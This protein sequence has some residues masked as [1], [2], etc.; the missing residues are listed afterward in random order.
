MINDQMTDVYFYS[1]LCVIVINSLNFS[2][3]ITLE[4]LLFV[5]HSEEKVAE[6]CF[7]H[8]KN[9]LLNEYCVL[10]SPARVIPA[11][12]IYPTS[13][14]GLQAH[15]PELNEGFTAGSSGGGK[16]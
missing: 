3:Y 12:G 15:A 10:F 16:H 6:L 7:L 4:R 1:T 8:K 5:S 11:C 9:D 2:S 14:T 13:L